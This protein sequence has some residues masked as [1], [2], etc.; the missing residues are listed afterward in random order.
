MTADELFKARQALGVSA[1]KLAK[2]LG[3]SLRTY[4][5]WEGGERD[6]PRIAELLLG[7]AV[8]KPYVRR[9]I[10]LESPSNFVVRKWPKRK[11]PEAEV[12]S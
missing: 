11:Q 5:N 9:A 4:H 8:E 6:T 7:L 10:G 2:A 1:A 12:R 3:V